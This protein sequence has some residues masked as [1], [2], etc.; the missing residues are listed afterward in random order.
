MDL[1]WIGMGFGIILF[2][3]LIGKYF[4]TSKYAYFK[5]N[6]NCES[7]GDVTNGFKCPKCENI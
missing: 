2:T 4:K 5:I 7:C 1:S 3:V 6:L